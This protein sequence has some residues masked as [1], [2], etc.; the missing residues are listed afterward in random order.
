MF[1]SFQ[2]N[3]IISVIL[4][5]DWDMSLVTV[6]PAIYDLFFSRDS[7]LTTTNVSQSVSHQ[8]VKSSL[9]Q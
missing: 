7:D 2:N 8:I 4:V 5:S 3:N 9:N 1:T 6:F